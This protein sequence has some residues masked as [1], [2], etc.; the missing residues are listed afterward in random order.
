ARAAPVTAQRLADEVNWTLERREALG[1]HVPLDPPAL[2]SELASAVA[3]TLA[4]GCR[5]TTPVAAALQDGAHAPLQNGA[6]AYEVCDAEIQ[7]IGP[8]S[9]VALVR[10]TMDAFERP[11][12]PRWTA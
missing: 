6:H 8:A 7:F 11:G 12:E 1:P 2:D 9:V 3:Q 4:S 10:D 5:K